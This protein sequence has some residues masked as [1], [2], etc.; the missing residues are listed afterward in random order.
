MSDSDL[1]PPKEPKISE[2]IVGYVY[3]QVALFVAIVY[4]M[5]N[6][7][8]WPYGVDRCEIVK[9]LFIAGFLITTFLVLINYTEGRAETLARREKIGTTR[10]LIG[11]AGG[12][13]A[14]LVLYLVVTH[15]PAT[16]CETFFS[17]SDG[18]K[19]VVEAKKFIFSFMV[20][21]GSPYVLFFYLF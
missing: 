4:G 15:D 18:F 21:C 16:S 12:V 11:R 20:V 2:M 3:L 13:M 10:T 5:K 7:E 19:S 9:F 8:L 17:D 1:A 6:M 14:L